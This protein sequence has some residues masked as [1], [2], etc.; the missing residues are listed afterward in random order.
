MYLL[1][2]V[3]LVRLCVGGGSCVSCCIF[4]YFEVFI[5]VLVLVV[6]CPRHCT[7]YYRVP[8]HRY[9]GGQLCTL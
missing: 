2:S 7:I 4:C 9:F 5:L 1:L 8:G 3:C 6:P